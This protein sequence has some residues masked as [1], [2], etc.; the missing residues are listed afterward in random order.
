M[1]HQP[2]PVF[3]ILGTGNPDHLAD[4]LGAVDV[5]LTDDQMQALE[6]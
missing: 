4:A 1:L 5:S 6:C 2:F 3:P